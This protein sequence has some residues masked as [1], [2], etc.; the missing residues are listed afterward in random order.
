MLLPHTVYTEG[1]MVV[2]SAQ[3]HEV[4][5]RTRWRL[6]AA[7][8]GL[9][10]LL[11]ACGTDPEPETAAPEDSP[12]PEETVEDEE[13]TDSSG[14][15]YTG[16][17]VQ[18]IVGYSPGGGFDTYARTIGRHIGR[19]LPGEP[20][21]VVEN[22][23][24]AGGLLMANTIFNTM[25]GDGT[26]IGAVLGSLFL[27][28][29]LGNPE[30]TFEGQEFNFIGAPSKQTTVC[31]VHEQSGVTSLDELE[32]R[33]EPIVMG[34]TAPG[35]ATVDVP[36]LLRDVVGLNVDVV[37]GY[38]G[39]AEVR[40]AMEQGEV[41]GGCWGWESI[42]ATVPEELE[43]GVFIPLVQSGFQP[44]ADMPDVP[45]FGDLVDD[46][47]DEA[48][49]D[50][51]ITVPAEAVRTFLAPPGVSPEEVQALRDAFAATL[52][53]DAFL[54]EASAQELD[55]VPVSGEE[56]DEL[57]ARFYQLDPDTVQRLEAILAE[58]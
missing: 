57:V 9:L 31:V 27:Q 17:T 38:D 40:L 23:P 12:P 34:G 29:V 52:Q 49:L 19:H 55:V 48:L 26:V 51:G 11:A 53:D 45:L 6:A 54:E 14:A 47:A 13:P 21:V 24:G 28:D 10:L 4:P 39:T 7:C 56:L 44:H 35:D 30:I 20:N 42:V 46:P 5:T 41:D 43:A 37:P 33:S 50:A 22:M 32:G 2:S 25:E 15:D 1:V 3:P 36:R 16:E 18:I 8:L 58:G